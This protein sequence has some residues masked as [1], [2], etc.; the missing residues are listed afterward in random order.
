MEIV[1]S[2]ND[3]IGTITINREKS[4]NSLSLRS[5]QDISQTLVDWENMP[6]IKVVII[7]GA[8]SKSFVSGADISEFTTLN[9]ED[10]LAFSLNGQEFLQKIE[11]YSKPVI[12]AINGYALGGGFEL[13]LACH[14]R[15]AADHAQLGL[16]EVKLGIIPGYGG[17]QRLTRLLGKSRA[18]Y[19]ALT[20]KS[21]SAQTAMEYGIV[22]EI[23]PLDNLLN[24]AN[25][26]ALTLA[27]MPRKSM[28]GIIA[29]CNAN[30]EIKSG[31]ATEA[32]CFE[33][34]VRHNDFREGV[35]AFLEKRVA[36]F[37]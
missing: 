8:G 30:D 7:T 20:G 15:I 14:L 22:A 24:A 31:Y 34:C 16:P 11:D 12:A 13:A 4:Y 2:I 6:E 23:H 28:S 18:L 10:A 36:I 33:Q 27:K 29:A 1:T 19:F 9:P 32:A 17:T 26:L 35:Q 25:Q 37:E 3:R 21:M 5:I